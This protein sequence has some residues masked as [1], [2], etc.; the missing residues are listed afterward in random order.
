M[1]ATR[2]NSPSTEAL[3]SD[4]TRP[5]VIAGFGVAVLLGFGG[6]FVS[7]GD[8]QNVMFG[9]SALGLIVAS[10]LLAI[11]HAS[12][13]DRFAAGGFALLALGET[14]ILNPTEVPGFEASFAAGVLLYAPGLLLVAMSGWAPR[15]V[16]ALGVIAAIPFAA[17]G[18]MYLG[19]AAVET[20]GPF[21]AT[22]YTLYT[23]TVIGWIIAVVRPRGR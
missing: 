16:R 4:G 8:V 9:V 10:V 18:L 5:I 14:R 17:H 12:A 1:I 22:G 20:T 13:G 2:T 7:P 19:G 21:A 11:E 15:W 3:V 23:L 6:N